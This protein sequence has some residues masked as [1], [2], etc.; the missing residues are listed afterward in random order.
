LQKPKKIEIKRMMIKF[1][2]KKLMEGEIK[3]KTILKMIQNKI[4]S[5]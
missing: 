2:R 4:N 1:K 3:K 5:N